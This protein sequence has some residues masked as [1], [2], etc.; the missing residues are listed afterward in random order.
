MRLG[1]AFLAVAAAALLAAPARAYFVNPIVRQTLG[2]RHYAATYG[3]VDFGE[4]FHLK[5]SFGSYHSDDATGTF[6]TYGLKAIYDGELYSVAVLAGFTPRVNGYANRFVGGEVSRT[7]DLE[8]AA[9]SDRFLKSVEVT[10]V[11]SQTEHSDEFS[12]TINNKGKLVLIHST[13]STINVAQTDLEGVIAA[14]MTGARL[15]LDVAKSVYNQDVARIGARSA[16]ATYLSGLAGVVQGFPDLN[17]TVRADCLVWDALTP[18]TS[19]TYTSYKVQ[20]RPSAAYA[21]GLDAR[22]TDALR[23]G[24]TYQRLAQ[25]G[26]G[27]D[28]SYYALQASY[29]FE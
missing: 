13:T 23:A 26:A 19:Y 20:Q 29:R 22:P 10:G 7:F 18:W 3:A 14:E 16:Q 24:L 21:L 5:P 12:G 25:G 27:P 6:K 15:E 1:A 9:G 8:A 11:L 4:D 2:S 17:V 28:R